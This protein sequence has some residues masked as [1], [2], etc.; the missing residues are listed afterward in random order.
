[1]GAHTRMHLASLSKLSALKK[2][3]NFY[4]LSFQNYIYFQ[5]SIRIPEELV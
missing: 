5:V 4:A 3:K 2:E 1:V